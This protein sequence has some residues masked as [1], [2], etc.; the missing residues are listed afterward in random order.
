MALCDIKQQ[1]NLTMLLT[2]TAHHAERPPGRLLLSM[3]PMPKRMYSS[4]RASEAS[5]PPRRALAV[6]SVEIAARQSH[7]KLSGMATSSLGSSSARWTTQKNSR[8]K[9]MWPTGIG[10]A[11]STPPMNY[12]G[13]SVFPPPVRNQT[14]L[15]RSS[16]GSPT[17]CSDCSHWSR[18]SEGTLRLA[19]RSVNSRS[20]PLSCL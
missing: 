10:S 18:R 6:R 8:R 4:L 12:L 2:A 3:R 19:V 16:V 11:G 20:T 9:N 14:I 5:L 1:L 17:L 7:T 15:D 13:I